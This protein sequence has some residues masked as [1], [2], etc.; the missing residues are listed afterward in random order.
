MSVGTICSRN[1]ITVDAN[2]PVAVA[3]QRMEESRVGCLV[4]VNE[5]RR[6]FGILTDRDLA[7]KC[8]QATNPSRLQMWEVM[9]P[10][11]QCVKEDASVDE[12]LR[13]MRGGP[14]RRLPVID[15]D[16]RAVG[17]LSVDDILSFVANEIDEINRLIRE[18]SPTRATVV[19]A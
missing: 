6:P 11:P 7:F 12:A 19:Q 17:L 15:R 18:E 13:L 5:D 16:G 8:A 9:K 10:L 14:Y 2:D 1:L 4:V 3:Q